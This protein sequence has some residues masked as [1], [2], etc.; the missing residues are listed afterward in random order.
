MLDSCIDEKILE[1]LSDNRL[2]TYQEI[3][4]EIEV[5][6][7]TVIKHIR[8]LSEHH[9]ITSYHGGAK[10]GIKLLNSKRVYLNSEEKSIV[11]YALQKLD[12]PGL[13]R[14]IAKF[15]EDNND[16]N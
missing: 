5:H 9:N 13:E 2:H 16:N 14:L 12:N 15:K 11:I 1:C 8:F 4:D 3:A 7:N 10:K 6:R